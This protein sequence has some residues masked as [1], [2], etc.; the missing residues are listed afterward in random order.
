M[1]WAGK[2]L[3]YHLTT[4]PLLWAHI[5]LYLGLNTSRHGVSTTSQ[6]NLLQCLTIKN[7]SYIPNLNSSSLSLKP[8]PLVPSLQFL[9]KSP[10]PWLPFGP[11][12]DTGSLLRD[13]HVTF[14]S[15][16]WTSSVSSHCLQPKGASGLFGNPL[17]IAMGFL[18]FL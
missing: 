1:L 17:S 18:P 7:F 2:D 5:P 4:M 12:S 6:G 15:P 9:M 10:S 11:P 13:L 8:F 16:G 14:S 3:K